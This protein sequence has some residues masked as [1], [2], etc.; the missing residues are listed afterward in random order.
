MVLLDAARNAPPVR[1]PQKP[2][3]PSALAYKHRGWPLVVI[4]VFAS[5]VVT[6]G[7]CTAF[8]VLGV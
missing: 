7:V 5:L 4:A 6:A 8:A 3:D 1:A 2:K